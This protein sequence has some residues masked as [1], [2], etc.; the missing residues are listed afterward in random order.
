V[1]VREELVDRCRSISWPTL[2]RAIS[3]YSSRSS[4]SSV[5]KEALAAGQRAP[6]AVWKAE[7]E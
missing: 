3:R 7:R 1:D 2:L 4:R 6:A 5:R